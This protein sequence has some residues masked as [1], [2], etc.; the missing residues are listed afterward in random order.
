MISFSGQIGRVDYNGPT[1][2]RY[3]I[4]ENP[5]LL[6]Q[7]T[8]NKEKTEV[9][10]NYYMANLS[11]QRKFS[12]EGHVLNALIFYSM[13]EGDRNEFNNDYKT[14]GEW[15]SLLPEPD[16]DRRLRNEDKQEIRIKVDYSLPL[17]SLS[18]IDAGYQS[19]LKPMN[20]NQKFEAWNPTTNAWAED[21]YYKDNLFFYNNI[22]AFYA[23]YKGQFRQFEYQAGLRAEYTDRV[24]DQK[25]LDK[26]YR[27]DKL[28]FFPSASVSRQFSNDRQL[29]FSYSRRINRPNEQFLNPQPMYSDK[30]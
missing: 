19:N 21:L 26:T 29:Q 18:Q 22:H 14:S 24:L 8:L 9:K 25:I 16:R 2:T 23:T 3:H 20:S 11:Y 28:D 1:E 6:M 17:D 13:W 4:W 30:N 12:K 10:G 5:E 7:Y 15:E 27:Y